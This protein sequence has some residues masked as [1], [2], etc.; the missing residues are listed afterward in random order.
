MTDAAG[1]G[2]PVARR[3]RPD[4]A[5]GARPRPR[6]GCRRGARPRGCRRCGRRASRPCPSVVPYRRRRRA[7]VVGPRTTRSM[8]AAPGDAAA[9]LLPTASAPPRPRPRAPGRTVA[10][11]L[12][13]V[14]TAPSVP[15]TKTWSSSPLSAARRRAEAVMRPPS[16]VQDD[17]LPSV[18]RERVHSASSRA[19]GEHLH[20]PDGRRTTAGAPRP[21]RRAGWRGTGRRWSRCAGR[22]CR[23]R[24]R[25]TTSAVP[26]LEDHTPR[27]ARSG[28]DASSRGRAAG[29]GRASPARGR[30]RGC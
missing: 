21:S 22:R 5:V 4:G 10:E 27:S 1:G 16:E 23:R 14:Q 29:R 18:R 19:A 30:P 7:G 13:R 2:Q 12:R 6:A 15:R 25:S 20:V 28:V 26:A 11:A 17:Q 24:R 3:A 9:G 8:R